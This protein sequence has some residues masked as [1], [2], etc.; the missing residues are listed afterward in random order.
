MKYLKKG[1]IIQFSELFTAIILEVSSY[2]ARVRIIKFLSAAKTDKEMII[3]TKTLNKNSK[4]LLNSSKLTK[5][6]YE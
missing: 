2:N 6:L 1:D 4:I 5:M 3:N